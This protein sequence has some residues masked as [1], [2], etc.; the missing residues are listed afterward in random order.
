MEH[1]FPDVCLSILIQVDKSQRAH[2]PVYVNDL[3][4]TYDVLSNAGYI[5]ID[6]SKQQ[7]PEY[8]E[9]LELTQKGEKILRAFLFRYKLAN[10][11]GLLVSLFA[12]VG[13]GAF[14]RMIFNKLSMPVPDFV[15]G[16]L[17]YAWF[18]ICL[19]AYEFAEF[20]QRLV[21]DSL[22]D[23][24]PR[25]KEIRNIILYLI[26]PLIMTLVLFI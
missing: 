17:T 25:S 14:F 10:L 6:R 23:P 20:Y 21:S 8:Y 19:R 2:N 5:C 24:L 1:V 7:A 4:D 22:G 16:I 3:G 11:F 13:S 18:I 12:P 15:T 9:Y 26:A